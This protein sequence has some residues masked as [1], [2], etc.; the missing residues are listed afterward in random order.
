MSFTR[1]LEAFKAVPEADRRLVC[2]CYNDHAATPTYCAIGVVCPSTRDLSEDDISTGIR[3]LTNYDEIVVGLTAMGLTIDEAEDLQVKNDSL[4]S[5]S[6]TQ[7]FQDVLE[8]LEAQV[9]KEA[10]TT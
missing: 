7:R 8:W 6:R 3:S 5:V 10:T 4:I 9:A 1:V 2:G